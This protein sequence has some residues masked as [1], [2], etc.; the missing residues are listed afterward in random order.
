SMT[1]YGLSKSETET[2]EITVEI[3]SLNSKFLD[4][5]FRVPKEYSDRELEIRSLL[6][7]TLERGKITLTI[8]VQQKG[9]AKPK[10]FINKELLKQYYNELK[11]GAELV[12]AESSEL[13]KLALQLPKVIDT[14]SEIV[15]NSEEWNQIAAVL[16]AAI[17]KCEDFRVNEGKTLQNKMSEYIRKIESLLAKVEEYD[18]ARIANIRSRIQNHF[19]EYNLSDQVEQGR[20]E[21]ELIY[22]I[23]KLDIS[24]EKVRLKKHL[25]YFLETMANKDAN[26]KKLGFISQEIGREINTI[27]S[28]ANDA[29]IQRLVVEMKE[30]LEKI[31]E[32]SLNIL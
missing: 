14:G 21:Q 28:K 20:F 19:K 27:G 10:V 18:P 31:K 5:N 30:E 22:Y 8:D 2:L 29:N 15:D 11:E 7:S 17:A 6:S 16:K 23:E 3:K 13:F 26:G 12:G 32:Q 9:E 24:E 25:D 1:G 4:L